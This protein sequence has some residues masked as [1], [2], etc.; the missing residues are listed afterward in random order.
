MGDDG[1]SRWLESVLSL[2]QTRL[3]LLDA[4]SRATNA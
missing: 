1:W 2:Q 4:L 3:W